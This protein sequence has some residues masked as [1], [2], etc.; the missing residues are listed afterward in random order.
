MLRTGARLSQRRHDDLEHPTRLAKHVGRRF[1]PVRHD[2]RS[3]GY[4]HVMPLDHR[5]R[6]ADHGFER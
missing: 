3:P 5:A 6:E 2:R 4:Q 1:A